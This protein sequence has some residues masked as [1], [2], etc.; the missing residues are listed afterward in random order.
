MVGAEASATATAAAA[1]TGLGRRDGGKAE[2]IFGVGVGGLGGRRT[3]STISSGG[4][5]GAVGDDGGG[6]GGGWY[7]VD[8]KVGTGLRGLDDWSVDRVAGVTGG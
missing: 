2:G 7:R 4:V 8:G 6:C 3:V 5:D 1:G